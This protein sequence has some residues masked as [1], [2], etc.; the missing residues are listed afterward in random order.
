MAMP[1]IALMWPGSVRHLRTLYLMFRSTLWG[2]P[3]M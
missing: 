1:F 3:A 2:V